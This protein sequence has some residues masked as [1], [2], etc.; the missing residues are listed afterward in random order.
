M[1]IPNSLKLH[2]DQPIFLKLI[3]ELNT[4]F[5]VIIYSQTNAPRQ[6][7]LECIVILAEEHIAI[8]AQLGEKKIFSLT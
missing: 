3:Y 2:G 6:V 1:F 4:L 8:R 5:G 7:E